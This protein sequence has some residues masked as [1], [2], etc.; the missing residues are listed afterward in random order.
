MI[1]PTD[2][3]PVK[4]QCALKFGECIEHHSK[5]GLAS[6]IL[7]VPDRE[8]G[9]DIVREDGHFEPGCFSLSLAHLLVSATKGNYGSTKELISPVLLESLPR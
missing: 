4:G 6:I 1:A 5:L 8:S 7:D 2:K 9:D 3:V